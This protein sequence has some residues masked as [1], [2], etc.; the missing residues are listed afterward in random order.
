MF[1][2]LLWH[3]GFSPLCPWQI[4]CGFS[5]WALAPLA[6]CFAVFRMVRR[7]SGWGICVLP[8]FCFFVC[9]LFF[10]LW[11]A[12]PHDHRRPC[13]SFL[14]NSFVSCKDRALERDRPDRRKKKLSLPKHLLQHYSHAASFT[15][16]FILNPW[17][18][19][20]APLK[21]PWSPTRSSVEVPLKRG[22][23]NLTLHCHRQNKPSCAR[24]TWVS[25][26]PAK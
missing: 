1:L 9:W 13:S 23:L 25:P 3:S 14:T 16:P 6:V 7:K 17:S 10:W 21:H 24:Y 5:C 2:S 22:P 8:C 12:K 15:L 20:K 4:F 19:F 26:S 18:P 11:F